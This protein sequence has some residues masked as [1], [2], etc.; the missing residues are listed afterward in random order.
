M[1]TTQAFWWFIFNKD[2][3]LL[4]KKNGTY[5]IPCE[6]KPP[7]IDE[8]AVVYNIATL[9]GYPCQTFAITDSPENDEQYVMV[10]LRESYI[11]IPHEQ[12]AIAGKARQILHF[13][14]HTRFCAVCGNP[15]VQITPI[16][17]QCPACKEEYYPPIA[18]AI[19]ALV[20]KGDSVLLVHA[21]NFKGNFHGLVAG[22]LETGETL[23]ECVQREILEE[24]GLKVKNVV[25]FGNQPWAFPSGLMVGFIADYESGEITLQTDELSH[26][27]FYTKDTLPEL[28]GKISLA[29]KM[30]DWWIENNVC[31][32]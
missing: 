15:T 14:C 12:F 24:T 4:K 22:F 16:F 21:H 9:D 26:G 1:D 18:I 10:G 19:L 32:Q 28:P 29:R 3:L 13:N 7:I 5:T 17:R 27:A 2:Q 8:T 30:I 31:N 23:E 20:R 6:K 11:N 25:Y